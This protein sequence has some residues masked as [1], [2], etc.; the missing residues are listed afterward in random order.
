MLIAY[1]IMF[2]TFVGVALTRCKQR[3]KNYLKLNNSRRLA[4]NGES[5]SHYS[6]KLRQLA[7]SRKSQ[8]LQS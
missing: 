7:S 3:N 5:V 6:I 1:L 4:D 2:T 8:V